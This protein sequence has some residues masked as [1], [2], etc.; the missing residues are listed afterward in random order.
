[1]CMGV[2]VCVCALWHERTS[3]RALGHGKNIKKIKSTVFLQIVVL[4]FSMA[5]VLF[6]EMRITQQL[7]LYGKKTKIRFGVS[8]LDYVG[9]LGIHYFK[10]KSK[11]SLG[12]PIIAFIIN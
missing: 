7:E 1:M 12:L 4:L 8:D 2:W 6:E 9:K 5:I 11:G 3:A 10:S